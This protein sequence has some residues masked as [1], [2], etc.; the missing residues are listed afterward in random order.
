M[1]ILNMH[2]IVATVILVMGRI[3]SSILEA[4]VV[5][6]VLFSLLWSALCNHCA[7]HIYINNFQV[8]LVAK[9][10]LRS[11]LSSS[12]GDGNRRTSPQLSFT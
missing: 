10:D 6:S 2:L 7:V 12:L 9:C 4:I 11:E 8:W 5:N 1:L 3:L